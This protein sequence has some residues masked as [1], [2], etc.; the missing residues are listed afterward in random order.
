MMRNLKIE[1]ERCPLCDK[2]WKGLKRTNHHAIPVCLNPANNVVIP[3]CIDC[4]NKI[5][6]LFISIQPKTSKKFVKKQNITFETFKE[7]YERLREQFQLKKLD[8]SQFGEGLWKNLVDYLESI[9][10]KEKTK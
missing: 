9:S 1:M 5:N 8:R 4:H 7:E 10:L 6:S 2:D 3:I